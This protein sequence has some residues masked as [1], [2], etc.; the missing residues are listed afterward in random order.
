MST[1]RNYI[2]S[3]LHKSLN[4]LAQRGFPRAATI[5]LIVYF[6]PR[7]LYEL[8]QRHAMVGVEDEQLGDEVGASFADSVWQ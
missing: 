3:S 6:E 7:M 5:E 1:K 2:S 4:R 8:I